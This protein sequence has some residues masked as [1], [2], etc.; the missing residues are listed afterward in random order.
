MKK[1][2]ILFFLGIVSVTLVG[3]EEQPIDTEV[4]VQVD[5]EV[6]PNHEDCEVDCEATPEHEDCEVDCEVTP[7]DEECIVEGTIEVV[8]LVGMTYTEA[9]KWA[10]DNKVSLVPS[11]EYRDDVLPNTVFFQDLEVGTMIHKWAQVKISYSRGYSPDGEISVPDFTGSTEDE[12]KT[13]LSDNDIGQYYF[14]ETFSDT[15]AGEF[16]RFEV[17]KRDETRD[18]FARNDVYKFYYSRGPLTADEVEWHNGTVRG[19]NLGGWFVLESWMTPELFE[20]IPNAHD[21]TTWIINNPNAEAD[22][23]EHWETFIT[24]ED[25]QYLQEHGVEY[26]RLP[27]PWWMWGDTAYFETRYEDNTLPWWDGEKHVY[28]DYSVTYINSVYYIDRAMEWA[29]TY[30][31]DVLV[32]LHTAP[33]GQNGF[34]NGGLS[35]VNVWANDEY[36]TQTL[37]VVRD[38]VQHFNQ[39]DSFWG[40]ELLNEPGWGVPLNVLQDYYVDGYN[41]IRAYNPDVWVGMHDGFRMY[42]ETEWT[43]FFNDNE[44][45]NVFFDIHLYQVFGDGWS[46]MSIFE[47]L[48]WVYVEQ[49][50]AVHRYD[51]IVPIVVGEWSGGLPPAL[52]EGLTTEQHDLLKEAFLSAQLNEYEEGF[53]HFFWSYQILQGTHSEW[54]FVRMMEMGLIPEDWSDNE[55]TE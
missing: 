20:G 13:W 53:G 18:T 54:D 45:H 4:P 17:E 34:D 36:V 15:T 24:E 14:Y 42:M 25:F 49:R 29:E 33:G 10:S 37:L 47:H 23:I 48:D 32:D 16:V 43:N 19:V 8:D 44:F 9:L 11:S 26:I 12:I 51:G 7:E 5:C 31:I 2:F 38:M 46:D 39:F 1:L 21:E 50:K 28:K 3:C 35:G 27:I 41:I 6:T 55:G 22:L 52:Y 30:G 40:F